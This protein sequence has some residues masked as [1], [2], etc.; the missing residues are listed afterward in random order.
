MEMILAHAATEKLNLLSEGI[1][2]VVNTSQEMPQSAFN[3]CLPLANNQRPQPE[4]PPILAG[5]LDRP[6]A[7]RSALA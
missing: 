7:R 4:Q 6:P 3:G 2:S 1:L 5:L